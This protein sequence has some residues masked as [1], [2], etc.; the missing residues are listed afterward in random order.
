[1]W[2]TVGDPFSKRS[3]HTCSWRP[4]RLV[5]CTLVRKIKHRRYT[6]TNPL[7]LVPKYFHATNKKVQFGGIDH[8]AGA[9]HMPKYYFSLLPDVCG[10]HLIYNNIVKIHYNRVVSTVYNSSYCALELYRGIGEPELYSQILACSILGND[11][12]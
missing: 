5:C 4:S 6:A 9:S 1:M 11:T 8:K 12:S 10:V 2:S 3:T 7:Q